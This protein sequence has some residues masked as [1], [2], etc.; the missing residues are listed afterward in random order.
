MKSLRTNCLLAALVA[1][2]IHCNASAITF[3]SPIV[4]SR[5]HQL[6]NEYSLT[7]AG[8]PGA[9]S[10]APDGTV[11]SLGQLTVSGLTFADVLSRF[12]GQWT[13]TDSY[14]LPAG[15]PAQRHFFTLSQAQLSASF[16]AYPELLTP[17]DGATVPPVFQMTWA[18][19][20]GVTVIDGGPVE[21]DF[22]SNNSANVIVKFAPGEQQRQVT[23]LVRDIEARS[24]GIA[25]P[26]LTTARNRFDISLWYRSQSASRTVNAVVPEPSACVLA[27]IACIGLAFRRRR[28]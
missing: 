1:C 20:A 3:S 27:A 25:A 2:L 10:T 4:L 7:A 26:E 13:I 11:F 8:Y 19:D 24:V 15:A 18:G 28:K 14:D 21:I 6:P 9:T 12:S 5:S 17:D 23:V 22:T 16:P